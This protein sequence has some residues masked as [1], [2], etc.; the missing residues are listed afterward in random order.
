MGKVVW[1]VS[2]QASRA[3]TGLW[4][5]GEHRA[6]SGA[7]N[8]GIS[9]LDT[10]GSRGEASHLACSSTNRSER[11]S[12]GAPRLRVSASCPLPQQANEGDDDVDVGVGMGQR[13]GRPPN[14]QPVATGTQSILGKRPSR[15]FDNVPAGIYL[16]A[17]SSRPAKRGRCLRTAATGC[18]RCSPSDGAGGA[19][20][21]GAGSGPRGA[22]T[23]IFAL[24][25]PF[26]H[27]Q[28]HLRAGRTR[29]APD[30][31]ERARKS[32]PGDAVRCESS[33]L[34]RPA[35]RGRIAKRRP[36]QP[37]P[38]EARRMLQFQLGAYA[39]FGTWNHGRHVATHGHTRRP[40]PMNW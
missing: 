40:S 20:A 21:Q 35:V 18:P 1:Q 16:Y 17:G 29:A 8:F 2:G 30:V 32:L 31:A 33:A 39:C 23:L 38:G 24:A 14:P 28:R 15:T 9:E 25:A 12:S 4:R 3:R 37:H 26:V 36:I 11:K 34:W 27:R 7:P 13:R 10:G 19:P 5:C 22:S 6:W